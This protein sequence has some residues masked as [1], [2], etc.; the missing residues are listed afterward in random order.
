MFALRHNE[1]SFRFSSLAR[2]R[3]PWTAVR[4]APLLCCSSNN[5]LLASISILTLRCLLR[6][7]YHERETIGVCWISLCRRPTRNHHH[8]QRTFFSYRRLGRKGASLFSASLPRT[9]SLI[10]YFPWDWYVSTK[11]RLSWAGTGGTRTTIV[12]NASFVFSAWP[13]KPPP[14]PACGRMKVIRQQTTH[15]LILSSEE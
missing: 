2:R 9:T 15:Y 3:R 10:S 6:H 14:P 12:A 7:G 11:A 4:K 1:L 5:S 8:R 13:T